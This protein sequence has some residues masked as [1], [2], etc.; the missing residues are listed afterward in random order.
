MGKSTTA[1]MFA[2]RGCGVWDADAAVHRLYAS[3]GAA[4]SP[5][6][7]LRPEAVINGKIDRA[8]LRDWISADTNALSEI[9]NIVHPLVA[10]DRADFIAACSAQIIVLDIPLLFENNAQAGFDATACVSAPV[11]AQTTRVL[12]R[13]GMTQA[14][15]DLILSRQMPNEEKCALADYVINT[16]TLNSAEA[17]VVRVLDAIKGG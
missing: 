4:V 13:P 3:G 1:A 5:L 8:A 10:K 16:T 12:A 7:K 9:E 6:A 2:A 11:E 15:F 14:Q 17:D